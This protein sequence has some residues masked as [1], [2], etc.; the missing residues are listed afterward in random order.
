MFIHSIAQSI[1]TLMEFREYSEKGLDIDAV[2]IVS[3]RVNVLRGPERAMLAWLGRKEGLCTYPA[4][5]ST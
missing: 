2:R 1:V 4:A 5:R 3:E